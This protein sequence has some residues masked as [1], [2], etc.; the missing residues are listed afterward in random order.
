MVV[1]AVHVSNVVKKVT[2]REIV[3]T[4]DPV[5]VVVDVTEPVSNVVKKATCREIVHP[6]VVVVEVAEPVSN[7][8]RKATCLEI[9][10]SQVV[11][12]VLASSVV[13]KATC[14][15]TVLTLGQVAEVEIIIYVS[16]IHIYSCRQSGHQGVK[17][18]ISQ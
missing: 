15:A 3:Q 14:L 10:L 1:V 13:K 4:Q 16:Y 8:V 6:V 2:C 12:V 18:S 17:C 5:V 9:V 7:A 11:A